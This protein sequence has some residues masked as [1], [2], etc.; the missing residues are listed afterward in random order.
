L[1]AT[2]LILI[3]GHCC[4]QSDFCG[5][6]GTDK[7]EL[8]KSMLS[9]DSLNAGPL[10]FKGLVSEYSSY[11]ASKYYQ[12]H[13]LKS[14]GASD[15]LKEVGGSQ[16][17]E[18][19]LQK[20][21]DI[22]TLKI[23]YIIEKKELSQTLVKSNFVGM[24][25]SQVHRCHI[26]KL[27]PNRV[28]LL[29]KR[30]LRCRQDLLDGKLS[31]LVQ[32][33][34]L[35]LEGDSSQ[36]LQRGKWWMK[37]SSAINEFPRIVIKDISALD[38]F[39]NFMGCI[40]FSIINIKEIPISVGFSAITSHE[41]LNQYS[42]SKTS[43]TDERNSSFYLR[44]TA[45]SFLIHLAAFEDELLREESTYT[46]DDDI[47]AS[48]IE[49]D[50]RTIKVSKF[51]NFAIISMP[52]CPCFDFLNCDTAEASKKIFEL[53]ITLRIVLNGENTSSEELTTKINFCFQL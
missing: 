46:C 27:Y 10:A 35:P 7:T 49:N 26:S 12:H 44:P 1:D 13:T 3:C 23:S 47:V 45:N 38:S 32:P 6:F 11:D 51:H 5:I 4:W 18:N 34:T 20:Y 36:K 52:F 25:T 33:K 48:D 39:Q 19:L 14:Q 8:D 37:D 29:S 15:S 16:D 53:I 17:D 30:T 43:D 9:A 22:E 41:E 31:I 28:G 2:K 40:R 21:V 24:T 50:T 42:L